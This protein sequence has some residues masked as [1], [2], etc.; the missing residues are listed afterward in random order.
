MPPWYDPLPTFLAEQPPETVC[1]TLTYAELEG[2]ADGP[3]PVGTMTRYYW[4]SA[5]RSGVVLRLARVGWRVGSIR[6]QPMVITFVRLPR[7]AHT[8]LM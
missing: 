3:L 4:W 7:D 8:E 2:L 1:L 5:A 6:G